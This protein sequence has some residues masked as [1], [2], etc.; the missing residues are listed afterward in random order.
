[1]PSSTA[2]ISPASGSNMAHF[3]SKSRTSAGVPRYKRKEKR[4]KG[5]VNKI[6][7]PLLRLG[8]VNDDGTNLNRKSIRISEFVRKEFIKAAECFKSPPANGLVPSLL[9]NLSD[10]E[11]SRVEDM[12]N[13]TVKLSCKML[14]ALTR[15]REPHIPT[16][17]ISCRI[18][19]N[20][21]AD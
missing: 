21:A 5:K 6:E 12:S 18:F 15:N 2:T 10:V 8:Y 9:Q 14:H 16:A 13:D 11:E 1:M 7:H 19:G 20:R 17:S 4:A 3:L